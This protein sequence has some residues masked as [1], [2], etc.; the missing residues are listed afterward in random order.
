MFKVRQATKL[1]Y[2]IAYEGDSINLEQ[3]SS[4]TRRG[5]VGE[6]VSQTLQCNDSMGVI[7][8]E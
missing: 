5:R 4:K 8:N 2:D 3:P 6:Q 7:V 1:G